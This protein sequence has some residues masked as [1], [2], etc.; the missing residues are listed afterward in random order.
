MTNK[1]II[2]QIVVFLIFLSLI[3]CENFDWNL[4]E[5]PIIRDIQIQY[6]D[7]N[8]CE[9]NIDI[10]FIKSKKVNPDD[11]IVVQL[12]IDTNNLFELS[13]IKEK[14]NLGLNKLNLKNLEVN[15]LYFVKI[16]VR[17]QIGETRSKFI[18]FHTINSGGLPSLNSLESSL[19]NDNSS[20]LRG[21]IYDTGT[22]TIT[23][24]GF[25]YSTS[26]DP[27]ILNL[28]TSVSGTSIGNFSKTVTD[29]S[30]N[31][32]Y[33]FRAFAVNSSG[34]AY[35]DV[36]SF[37]TTLTPPFIGKN[38]QGGIIAYVDSSGL[39]G[40]IAAPFDQIDSPWGCVGSFIACVDANDGNQNTIDILNSCAE[41]GIAAKNCSDLE[42]NGFIDWYLPSIQELNYLYDSRSLIGGFITSG[43]G[44]IWGET[45]Y[46]SST[47][48][49]LN[50]SRFINFV[51]GYSSSEI[52]SATCHVRAVRKF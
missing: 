52:K 14:V 9:I 31:T 11:V 4:K 1:S 3:S 5:K 51:G 34:V 37:Q 50:Y 2:G 23:S 44:L 22:S 38:Y 8:S 28:V 13:V 19:M 30:S 10:E 6:I 47:E 33:F 7:S 15:K 48:S 45:F 27:T 46:W 26:N 41:F 18:E 36:L 24:K 25:C 21:K 20:F 29:L 39:H 12:Y 35:G 17:N 40:I 49:T 43:S 42:L 16:I 32:T